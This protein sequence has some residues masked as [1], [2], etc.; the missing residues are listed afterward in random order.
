MNNAR[1]FLNIYKLTED[2]ILRTIR[3]MCFIQTCAY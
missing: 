1:L 3:K 2:I